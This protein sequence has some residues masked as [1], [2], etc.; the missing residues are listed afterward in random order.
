MKKAA[1]TQ[2]KEELNAKRQELLTLVKGMES[3]RNSEDKSSAGDKHET[4]RAMAQNELDKYQNQLSLLNKSL[5]FLG[6][7]DPN[8]E[9]KT[10]ESGALVKTNEGHYLF[11]ISHGRIEVQNQDLFVI[12]MAAPIGQAFAAKKVGDEILFQGRNIKI[13]AIS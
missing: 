8:K 11:A 9:C 3:A 6:Q 13:E 2:L 12:S 10:I 7:I 5:T 1:F 4:A